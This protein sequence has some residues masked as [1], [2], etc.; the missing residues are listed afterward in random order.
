M[1][2]LSKYAACLVQQAL[3]SMRFGLPQTYRLILLHQYNVQCVYIQADPH[4]SIQCTMCV[5]VMYDGSVSVQCL[6]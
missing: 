1:F 2:W 5:N 3:C 6:I 4:A